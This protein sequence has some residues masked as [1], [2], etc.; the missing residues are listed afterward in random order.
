[1]QVRKKP[2]LPQQDYDNMDEE[3][4]AD[5]AWKQSR[6]AEDSI[7]VDLFRVSISAALTCLL[8]FTLVCRLKSQ[9]LLVPG[10]C[11]IG[12]MYFLVGWCKRHLNEALILLCLV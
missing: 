4:A 12:L 8:A 10:S 11:S 6:L 2:I 9:A 7:I 3:V 5:I 1:M